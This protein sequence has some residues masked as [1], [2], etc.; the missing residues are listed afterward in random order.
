M[1]ISHNSSRST[2]IARIARSSL[3]QHSFLVVISD[4][5]WV[6][7]L[8]LYDRS[9]FSGK[10]GCSTEF[11]IIRSALVWSKLSMKINTV[12]YDTTVSSSLSS[13]DWWWRECWVQLD[14]IEQCFMSL[15][16]QYRLYGRRFLQVKRPNQQ[17]QSRPTEG[18]NS[19]QTNQTYNKLTWTQNT[20]SPLVYNNM[21]W[22]GDGYHR[23]QG[24]QAWTA[25][26][27][28]PRYHRML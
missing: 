3:R 20:A 27:L 8:R 23:G 25:V 15:P 13:S 12:Y 11:D 6:R 7:S 28:P 17:Y 21:G 24:C 18:T 2:Y 16:T 19:T 26:G 14:W 9:G 4:R 1:A 22:L 10:N 5:L